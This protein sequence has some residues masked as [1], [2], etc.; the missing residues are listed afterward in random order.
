MLLEVRNLN[1]YYSDKHVLRN[2]SFDLKEGEV[3]CI[4][5][6]SGSGKTSIL[7]SIIGLLPENAKLEGSIRFK[8]QELVG[9]SEKEYRNIRGRHISIVFQEPSVYL[10]PLY[11]VGTQVEEAYMAHFGKEDAKE[12]A[13]QAL[14]KAGIKEVDRIYNSYPH[15]LSGGLRQRVCIAIATVCNPQLVLAD[16]PTTALD[17]SIQSRILKLFRAMKEENRSVILVTHDFGVV[18]EVADRVIVLKDGMM[19]EEG[20]VWSIFD[21]P[22]HPYTQELLRAI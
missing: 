14:Q 5:G 20:D 16:E 11:R 1:L 3:L 4:V 13:L 21:N 2:I 15:H 12:K 18:A 19:V 9:L 10:D 8:E 22:K 6:E 7:Y 17:V